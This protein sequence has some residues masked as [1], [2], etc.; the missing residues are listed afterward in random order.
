MSDDDEP[1]DNVVPFRHVI[2]FAIGLELRRYYQSLL[3]EELPDEIAA[4]AQEFAELS[5]K[6]LKQP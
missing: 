5:R 6:K 4:L 1:R 3:E 2:P